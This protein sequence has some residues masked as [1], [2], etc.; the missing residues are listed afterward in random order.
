MK[1]LLLWFII[2][3]LSVVS[4][5]ILDMRGKEY[6]KSYFKQDGMFLTVLIMT[7]FGFFSPF[8]V[9]FVYL[10]NKEYFV[11]FIYYIA[12]IGI[13]NEDKN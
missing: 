1:L 3:F 4:V 12:N 5:W 2:G 11:E 7:I 6:N 13:D 9:L 10:E 8:I